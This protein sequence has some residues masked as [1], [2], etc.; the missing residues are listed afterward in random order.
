MPLKQ[1]ISMSSVIRHQISPPSEASIEH[2]VLRR[3]PAEKHAC[4]GA[5]VENHRDQ[6]LLLMKC[7]KSFAAS[8]HGPFGKGRL[9][10]ESHLRSLRAKSTFQESFLASHNPQLA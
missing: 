8:C 5:A 1:P 6:R 3:G 9:L 7:T 10:P 4:G 2:V